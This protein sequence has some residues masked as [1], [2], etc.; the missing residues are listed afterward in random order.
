MHNCNPKNLLI[1]SSSGVEVRLEQPV[2]FQVVHP[3]AGW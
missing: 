3:K 2:T 1:L